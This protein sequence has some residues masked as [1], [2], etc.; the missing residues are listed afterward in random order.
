MEPDYYAILQLHAGATGEEVHR[1]YRALALRYHPDRNP[2]PD[3]AIVMA[4]INEAYSVLGEPVRRRAYD[5]RRRLSCESDVSL[6]ILTAARDT[7]LRQRWAVLE[8]HVTS[9]LLEKE[10]RQVRV[11]LVDVLNNDQLRS[12][13]RRSP[14][15]AV[16]LAVDI[17]KPINL[18][19]QVV[20]IDL[21]H[22][23]VLGSGFPEECYRTLFAPFLSSA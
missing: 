16:V 3:A 18:S 15:F 13:G 9:L 23:T 6:P 4:R 17:R 12:F 19:L 10:R 2:L 22:S 20:V 8:D 11:H 7:L 1:A 21:I 5:R 14:E